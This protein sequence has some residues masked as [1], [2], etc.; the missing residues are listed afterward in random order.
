MLRGTWRIV[1]GVNGGEPNPDVADNSYWFHDHRVIIGSQDAAWEWQ[2]RADPNL[3]PHTL[4]MWSN[5]PEYSFRDLGI[6]ELNDG[7]LRLCWGVRNSGIRP[8]AFESTAAN[9][10]QLLVLEPSEEPEPA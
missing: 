8:T 4:D 7:H 6:W 1:S 5:D 2:I 10:W 3:S 9:G